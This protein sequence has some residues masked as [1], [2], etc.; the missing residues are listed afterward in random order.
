[1]NAVISIELI[2][3]GKLLSRDGFKISWKL[4]KIIIYFIMDGE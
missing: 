4:I 1:M 2:L 3:S